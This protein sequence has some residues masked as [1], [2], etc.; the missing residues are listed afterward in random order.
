MLAQDDVSRRVVLRMKRFWQFWL[1]GCSTH[2]LFQ[3]NEAIIMS[4]PR[5]RDVLSATASHSRCLDKPSVTS[6]RHLARC[7]AQVSQEWYDELLT[8]ASKVGGPLLQYHASDGWSCNMQKTETA[9]L[10]DGISIRRVGKRRV[11]YL[12]ELLLLKTLDSRG[13]IVSALR[14]YQ[15][16]AMR[17]KTGWDIFASTL[18]CPS[19]L[20]LMGDNI[21]M[22][23][24]VQDGLH[25]PGNTKKQVAWQTICVETADGDE[26]NADM[27]DLD[28][29]SH[30]KWTFGWRCV[31]HVYQSGC[32]WGLAPYMTDQVQ[33]DAHI[34]LKSLRNSSGPIFDRIDDFIDT[35]VHYDDTDSD[36]NMKADLWVHLGVDSPTMLA[37]IL[38]VDP[39]WD[40]VFQ[41]LRVSAKLKIEVDQGK[42]KIKGILLWSFQWLNWSD[43]RWGRMPVCGRLWLRSKAVGLEYVVSLVKDDTRSSSDKEYIGGYKRF[44]TKEVEKLFCTAALGL[45]PLEYGLAV[46]MKDDRFL[47][48]AQEIREGMVERRLQVCNLP[49]AI[50]NLLASFVSLD[51][52]FDGWTLRHCTLNTMHIG[53]SYVECN[54]FTQLTVYPLKLTQGDVRE[55]LRELGDF[56]GELDTQTRNVLKCVT[57]PGVGRTSEALTLLKHVACSTGL[58]EKGH[59]PGSI[60]RRDHAKLE[61]RLFGE[62]AF[63]HLHTPL[64]K[65]S[66]EE[67]K[68]Q[69]M[70]EKYDAIV[71]GRTSQPKLSGKMMFLS[72]LCSGRVRVPDEFEG[73][74]PKALLQQHH[75]WYG[76]LAVEDRRGLAIRAVCE[77]AKRQA[78]LFDDAAKILADVHEA[79]E[80]MKTDTKGP[81]NTVQGCRYPER[82]KLRLVDLVET[83]HTSA[84]NTDYQFGREGPPQ[85]PSPPVQMAILQKIKQLSS[86]FAQTP[87]PWW[88]KI[89]ADCRDHFQNSVIWLQDGEDLAQRPSVVVMPTFCP[90]NAHAMHFLKAFEVEDER[91]VQG[92]AESLSL[93]DGDPS[94]TWAWH[95]KAEQPWAS[96]ADVGA[97][98]TGT[99]WVIPRVMLAG[100]Y[101]VGEAEPVTFEEY[102]AGMVVA[103]QNRRREREEDEILDPTWEQMVLD[104]YPWL[105]PDDIREAL[106]P[107][108]AKPR[109]KEG[110][111]TDESSD[112]PDERPRKE[113]LALPEDLA[114]EAVERLRQ[115]RADWTW[116]DA[117]LY[118]HF[119]VYDRRGLDCVA[120]YPRAHALHWCRW[121]GAGDM[122]SFAF[123]THGDAWSHLLA[124]EWCAKLNYNYQLWVDS[125]NEED[126]NYADFPAFALSDDYW[127]ALHDV[128]A[129]SLTFDRF[130]ELA[131]WL[132]DP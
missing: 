33:H 113:V 68:V 103:R 38:E 109:K 69:R 121:V 118:E 66:P 98:E 75:R 123:S 15:P 64:F 41:I 36:L 132:P 126:F 112:E 74:G 82:L 96:W 84:T 72:D 116:A 65:S 95:V 131:D 89:V 48:L 25:S 97:A 85:P 127:E 129:V 32:K 71:D 76:E 92:V 50:W 46:L 34:V 12:L 23:A 91:D 39:L 107:P 28:N 99:L 22:Q 114:A 45:K 5:I 87:R 81:A 9:P 53:M 62:R 110:G 10:S 20:H 13:N 80:K 44:L 8:M 101:I 124:R 42:G 47:L 86:D 88:A 122:H 63:V 58:A 37:Q 102:T 79:V 11:E 21:K 7:Q 90:Q 30:R 40:P 119:Y 54:A 108:K 43:T 59:A 26:E 6:L 111:T 100:Q 49:D 94:F 27:D 56:V 35:R 31:L 55:N 57:D 2:S 73:V 104:E 67:L 17:G 16:R 19:L 18:D 93:F 77:T 4:E 117:D 78:A 1:V 83:L 14:F 61:A 52:S 3:I 51:P 130:K 128:P 106:K 125:V 70:R 24:F 115:F 105:T 120:C 29:Q 60:L